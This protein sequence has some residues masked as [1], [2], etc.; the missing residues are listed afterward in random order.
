M[1]YFAPRKLP[2]VP[3]NVIFAIDISGSM[4]GTKIMQVDRQILYKYFSAKC[5]KPL[6]FSLV[7][8]VCS[9]FVNISCHLRNVA[10]QSK[11][12]CKQKKKSFVGG[13]LCLVGPPLDRQTDPFIWP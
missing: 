12:H 5:H 4:I 7:S 11:K 2:V 3:K 1:H 6:R 10:K 9:S 8:E 13:Q